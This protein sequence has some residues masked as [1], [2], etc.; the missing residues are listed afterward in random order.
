MND[1]IGEINEFWRKLIAWFEDLLRFFLTNRRHAFQ[2]ALILVSILQPN[3]ALC[4][5][6]IVMADV[7]GAEAA[8][9]I[10]C[11]AK[12]LNN[13]W[14]HRH[15]SDSPPSKPMSPLL[16]KVSST[17]EA[18]PST[19]SSVNTILSAIGSG[20]C[21]RITSRIKVDGPST[22]SASAQCPRARHTSETS[23]MNG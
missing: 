12:R 13:A 20:A 7:S 6:K 17:A 1:A 21:R 16:G 14:P 3:M 15:A 22:G 23:G 11:A 18:R 4:A 5:N 8:S 19:T 9:I 10:L 2:F